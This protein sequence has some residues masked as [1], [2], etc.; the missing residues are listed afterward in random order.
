MLMALDNGVKGNKWF[1]LIDKVY[2]AQTLNQALINVMKNKGA[3][4]I[5]KVTVK[6]FFKNKDIYIK[7]IEESIKLDK[8]EPSPIRRVEIPKGDCKTRPLGIPT[9]KDRIVQSAIKMVIEPIWEKEFLDSSYGF[10]PN[11]NAHNAILEV[12]Q[13]LKEGYKYV[14]DADIKGYFDNISHDKLISRLKERIADRRI[15]NIIRM[16]LK[17]KIL[18]NMEGWKPTKGTP[19]GGVLSPLLANIYLHPLDELINKSGYKIVRYADDFVVLCISE[20]E[21]IKAKT[22]IQQWMGSYELELHP[23]KTKICNCNNDEESFEFLGYKF[24]KGYKFVRKKSHDKLKNKIREY[25]KRTCG[26]N[27]GKV[28]QELNKVLVGW[29]N[30]FKFAQGKVYLETDMFIRRRL[31]AILRKQKKRPGLGKTFDDHKQWPN[32]FFAKLKLF[33]LA[34]ARVVF[35]KANRSR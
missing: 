1:S 25:T 7:E 30:Y 2:N 22:I 17:A 33:S 13:Y 10:R 3:A 19:Q 35:Y 8:Y 21:A 32:E 26:R 15:I 5:D 24:I 4:G 20:K 16:F 6:R 18:N 34:E 14:V 29:F 31:R 27:I 11:K 23:D 12:N 28:I 9:V